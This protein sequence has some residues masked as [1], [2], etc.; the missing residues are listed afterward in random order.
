MFFLTEDA[1]KATRDKFYM[2]AAMHGID[3]KKL[4]A[5]ECMTSDKPKFDHNVPLFGD[6]E[7][8]K[9]MTDEE[10]KKATEALKAKI[11]QTGLPVKMT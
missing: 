3:V 1:I 4:K 7:V 10:R 11:K 2:D 9:N 5:K 8:Y 6:P